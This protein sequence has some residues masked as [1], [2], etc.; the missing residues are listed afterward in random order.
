[1]SRS[2]KSLCWV[3]GIPLALCAVLFAFRWLGVLFL[4]ASLI[5][6]ACRVVL[7]TEQ[8]LLLALA[9]FLFCSLLPVDVSLTARK[10]PPKLLP[11]YYGKPGRQLLDRAHR[12]EVE[13]GGCVSRGYDPLWVIVW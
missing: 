7:R 1:M 8:A 9:G 12:G 2:T 10:G 4:V 3:L 13:L 6:I 11:I 5:L